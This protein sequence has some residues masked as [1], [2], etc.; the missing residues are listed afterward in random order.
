MKICGLTRREDVELAVGLGAD[1]LG[2][3]L[4]PASKRYV[5][6]ERWRN[7][8]ENLPEHVKRVAVI[9]D[10]REEELVELRKLF[11]IIQ[12]HGKESPCFAGGEGSWKALSPEIG[13][14]RFEQYD[15]EHFVVDSA[16]GGSGCCCDWEF[17]ALAA[18]RYEILL[19]GGL[20]PENVAE[21]LRRVKPWGVDVAGGVESSPGI[22]SEEKMER[23]IKEAK[24]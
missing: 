8:T 24:K 3:V 5:P 11:D 6:P 23:F 9:A 7:L 17:A 22:K 12:F 4:V 2:F 10:P 20:T 18:E 14:E 13:L 21:A 15:V 16:N 1:Y 19:A